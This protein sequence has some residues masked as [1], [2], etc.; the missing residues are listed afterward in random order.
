MC[1]A[2]G[3]KNPPQNGLFY[4]TRKINLRKYLL[5]QQKIWNTLN[6][7]KCFLVFGEKFLH[8]SILFTKMNKELKLKT[9]NSTY[10]HCHS[11]RRNKRLCQKRQLQ[12]AVHGCQRTKALSVCGDSHFLW[13]CTFRVR[14]HGGSLPSSIPEIIFCKRWRLLTPQLIFKKFLIKLLILLAVWYIILWRDWL[15]AMASLEIDWS[16]LI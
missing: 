15:V 14:T 4:V 13:T 5:S 10:R 7:S 9:Q 6:R 8:F 3:L 12:R 11:Y 16:N 2:Y 1:T